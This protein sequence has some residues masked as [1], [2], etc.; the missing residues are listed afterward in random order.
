MSRVPTGGAT[1]ARVICEWPGFLNAR[2]LEGVP[3]AHGSIAPGRLYRSD[4][5]RADAGTVLRTLSEEGIRTVLDLRS[6]HETTRRPSVLAG[7]ETYLVAPLVDPRR[8]HL[9]VPS[10]EE[11]LLDLYVGSVNRNGRTI[12]AAVRHVVDAP[13][14]GVLM[15][16]A[17]GKDRTG[18]LSAVILSALGAP[19]EV[20]IDEYARTGAADLSAFFAAEMA[21]I[22]DPVRRE[23]MSHRQHAHPDTM[24]GLLVHLDQGF[25][26]AASY[27]RAHGLSASEL[28][29]LAERLTAADDPERG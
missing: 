18:I 8:D 12:A 24:A 23:R 16:C 29:V 3:T 15:H 14:G 19:D 13:A 25:G 1:G 6:E 26:G 2:S 21:R 28:Q 5:P 22:E 27:L 11:S 20:V 7:S 10:S 17:I 4:E 9:R